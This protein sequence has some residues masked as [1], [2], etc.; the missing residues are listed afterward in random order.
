MRSLNEFVHELFTA[1]GGTR[2]QMTLDG[3]RLK[4]RV[5]TNGDRSFWVNDAMYDLVGGDTEDAVRLFIDRKM[6]PWTEKS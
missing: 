6:F 5:T 2:R 4:F 1:P 3:H